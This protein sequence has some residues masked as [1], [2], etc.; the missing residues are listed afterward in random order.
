MSGVNG[1]DMSLV[2]A[3]YQAR[4]GLL[5]SA[6][7]P[8]GTQSGQ[9]PLSAA[10]LANLPPWDSRQPKPVLAA[11]VR[12]IMAARSILDAGALA[13]KKA[14]LD[15]GDDEKKLF[16]VHR[17]MDRLQ[18]L[19]EAAGKAGVSATERKRL[20]DRFQKGLK[21]LDDFMTGLKLNRADLIKGMRND[22]LETKAFKSAAG[23]LRGENLTTIGPHVAVAD[24]ANADPFSVTITTAEG[25][26]TIDFDFD[27]M[28][29]T[30]RS[31]DNVAAYMNGKLET[32]GFDTRVRAEYKLD[33]QGQ[34]GWGLS[35]QRATGEDLTF[36]G[37]GV[38][39]PAPGG[40]LL[41]NGDFS[42]DEDADQ[43][44]ADGWTLGGQAALGGWGNVTYGAAVDIGGPQ[45][46]VDS[47]AQSVQTEAGK[48]YDLTFD[49]QRDPS[50]GT[51]RTEVLWNGQVVGVIDP[52][53]ANRRGAAFKVV[54]TGGMDELMFR[55][56]Q[57][58]SS[59]GTT[60]DNVRLQQAIVPLA[61]PPPPP[62]AGL[63]AP[64]GSV[65][66]VNANPGA[67]GDYRTNPTVTALA[68]GGTVVAWQEGVWGS[69]NGWTGK[70]QRYDASGAKVGAE[71]TFGA[72]GTS[73]VALSVTG[74]T[75]GGFVVGFQTDNGGG[76]W[77]T[78]FNI[79]GAD[80]T[81]VG[82][83]QSFSDSHVGDQVNPTV[84]ALADGGFAAT[85]DDRDTYT[86]GSPY[87]VR[88]RIF[89]ANGTARTG[90]IVVEG[91]ALDNEGGANVAQL[92]DGRIVVSWM[93][94]TSP[95]FRFYNANGTGGS[96][97]FGAAPAGTTASTYW[98]VDNLT[99]TSDGGFVMGWTDTSSGDLYVR[100]FDAAGAAVTDAIKVNHYGQASSLSVE[101][102]D[103]GGFVAAY[104][105][106]DVGVVQGIYTRTYDAAGAAF[107]SPVMLSAN[108]QGEAPNLTKTADGSIVAVWQEGGG[109][110]L[111]LSVKRVT[112]EQMTGGLGA[113]VVT[114]GSFE[115]DDVASGQFQY[116][117]VTGWIGRTA[118]Q[119]EIQDGWS[120]N[121]GTGTQYM[122]LM[123][124]GTRQSISTVAGQTYQLD[125]ASRFGGDGTAASN[126][127]EVWFAGT[128]IADINPVQG[129]PWR[130][131]TFSFVGVGGFADL[132]FRMKPGQEGGEG[133]LID[134]VQV[135]EVLGVSPPPPPPPAAY[136]ANIVT[137]GSFEGT[138]IASES[139]AMA[140]QPGWTAISGG[141]VQTLDSWQN[142]NA[143]DGTQWAEMDNGGYRQ[144]LTTEAGAQYRLQFDSR[145]GDGGTAGEAR[146]EVWWN[147]SKVADIDPASGDD[148]S[149]R[150]FT[151]NGTGGQAA[152]EFRHAA[153][154][155]EGSWIDKVEVRKVLTGA[156]PNLVANG[157]F[158]ADSVASGSF[159]FLDAP[160][161]WTASNAG[162]NEVID[163]WTGISGSDGAQ[164]IEL[165]S[166][167]ISQSVATQAGQAYTF[168]FDYRDGDTGNDPEHHFRVKV[169]G[170]VLEQID[171]NGA[172]GWTGKSYSFTGTGSDVIE[173]ERVNGGA[174]TGVWFDNVAVR[175]QGVS[176][177][178]PPPPP[179][180]GNLI[181]DGSFENPNLVNVFQTMSTAGAWTATGTGVTIIDGTA[182]NGLGATNGSQ[183]AELAGQDLNRTINTTAG[184]SYRLTFDFNAG[185]SGTPA[186]A[187][188]EVLWNGAVVA[189]MN[190]QDGDWETRRLDVTGTGGA[191]VLTFRRLNTANPWNGAWI[192][193]VALEANAATTG[194]NLVTNGGFEQSGMAGWTRTGAIGDITAATRAS[195]G[196]DF[197]SFN[198]G[199]V[200]PSGVMSQAIATT[201]GQSYAFEFDFGAYHEGMNAGPEL[202]VRAI[203]RDAGGT[204]LASR[205]FHDATAVMTT[206]GG[207][208]Q[209][210]RLDFTA[211][212]AGA[213]IEFQDISTGGALNADMHLDNV[214][215]RQIVGASPPPPP[216]GADVAGR[217]YGGNLVQ[218]GGFE[219]ITAGYASSLSGSAWSAT[220]NNTAEIWNA[221]I[222]AAQNGPGILSGAQAFHLDKNIAV[223]DIRQD[224]QTEA[225]KLYQLDFA[226]VGRS[227]VS[228]ASN[229]MEVLWNDKVIGTVTAA[230]DGTWDH[231]RFDVVGT[232]GL[233]RL[234]FRET[235][236]GND[237]VGA[238]IDD[239][240]LREVTNAPGPNPDQGPAVLGLDG[241]DWGT[242]GSTRIVDMTSAKIGD[243]L[244]I[245]VND[246]R[247]KTFTI[248]STMTMRDLASAIQREMG[249]AGTAKVVATAKGAMIQMDPKLGNRVEILRGDL[250]T[251]A[252]ADLGLVEG[253][254]RKL[255]KGTAGA[256]PRSV[257]ISGLR[258][259]E[260]TGT[261]GSAPNGVVPGAKGINAKPIAAIEFTRDLSIGDK[262]GATAAAE[263]LEGMMR[264][265]RLAHKTVT[266]VLDKVSNN[267]PAAK[268]SPG[269]AARLAQYKDA[270]SKIQST[271]NADLF[272]LSAMART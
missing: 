137:N 141:G 68:D 91:E 96:T 245:I 265:V 33:A 202:A 80:G 39:G 146:V 100:K 143:T 106:D 246:K 97:Q 199:N 266:G 112:L 255:G 3:F 159:V 103:G 94:G 252:L 7:T 11:E 130:N 89:N 249:S 257:F 131:N 155:T 232:G 24:F 192:D 66:T 225:G 74:L 230:A 79:Y 17:A 110:D 163:T 25:A 58:Q 12:K 270:L 116:L 154:A 115:V 171:A 136:G 180:V 54:G 157:S 105:S 218:D 271:N 123:N 4:Y 83:T 214:T 178:P 211:L 200:A 56:V 27:E 224:I 133:A 118:P 197:A 114:N 98:N 254:A 29:D 92:S 64:V 212:G 140:T 81:Q 166:N 169:N 102:T 34:Y 194:A 263:K 188:F 237:N 22:K 10:Q 44:T 88:M 37:G 162:A 179:P 175:A 48:T 119:G 148:W 120:P 239:V 204:I 260:A 222:N 247:E 84:T 183:V 233:D 186:E 205:D 113:N 228:S 216:P 236:G 267:L 132:E 193:N 67:G 242:G 117:N 42:L 158:E 46:A 19:S 72:T 226:T 168:S 244:S 213:T 15:K 71:T 149:T 206:A 104:K 73:E 142:W 90:E 164:Y 258:P 262:A 76:G 174:G 160:Q 2:G 165:G 87:D 191:D 93:D 78:R 60:I 5:D 241:A 31:L 185:D 62:P 108:A 86:A 28:G 14:R 124:G 176:P 135:R 21:E 268:F 41:V 53:D 111:G 147:G 250:K 1:F 139:W 95:S 248:T 203:V 109:N 121:P 219:A 217:T 30:I 167:S 227:G 151:L 220:S 134:A 208:Y 99:A 235:A 153:G 43:A 126:A 215:V 243:K 127:F 49:W 85:W 9:R 207:L 50:A 107:G 82:S 61:P 190:P 251:D 261:A 259:G 210:G 65:A 195:E 256:Q 150:T 189:T 77:N 6:P 69:P 16:A 40:N 145:F 52:Q 75:G 264:R 269:E 221:S 240:R 234:T 63:F 170:Q 161:G 35:I 231:V 129:D 272:A 51:G 20:D 122:E 59:V 125:F 32:A 18:T 201:A 36:D 70:F 196:T 38:S 172:T 209:R 156:G 101:A 198:A 144:M 223:D 182:L 55:E 13:L 152:L 8:A 45:S 173:F 138:D 57:G 238:L 229:T 128:K 47:I 177:P 23:V 26:T 253:V 181:P 184:Q 187:A